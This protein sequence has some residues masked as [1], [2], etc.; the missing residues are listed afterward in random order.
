MLGVC[1]NLKSE[2][3]FSVPPCLCGGFAGYARI[4]GRRYVCPSLLR[5]YTVTSF[6]LTRYGRP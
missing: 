1:K 4:S 3:V 5:W 6:G 2:I